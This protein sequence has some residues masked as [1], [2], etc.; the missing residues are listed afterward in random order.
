MY[1]D[2]IYI[3]EGPAHL[4]HVFRVVDKSN[5]YIYNDSSCTIPIGRLDMATGHIYGEPNMVTVP[6]G[7]I[8]FKTGYI[9]NEPNKVTVLIGI[10]LFDRK[11]IYDEPNAITIAKYSY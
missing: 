10:V 5:G 7:C 11:E 8:D 6:V 4:G 9:Y 1:E 3:Y 2:R